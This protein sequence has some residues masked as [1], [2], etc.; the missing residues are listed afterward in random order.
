MG[1]FK[2]HGCHGTVRTVDLPPSV[3]PKILN[4]MVELLR[5]RLRRELDIM[6]NSPEGGSPRS[7]M[8]SDFL[9][10]LTIESSSNTNI[11]EDIPYIA[12][13]PTDE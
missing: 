7:S 2:V 5:T 9:S 10:T 8:E 3:P 13:E 12:F 4:H 1:K 6:M 11:E